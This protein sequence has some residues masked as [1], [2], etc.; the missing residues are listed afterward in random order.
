MQNS[1]YITLEISFD[2]NQRMHK[3]VKLI[4]RNSKTQRQYY[5]PMHINEKMK[6]SKTVIF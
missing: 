1:K 4:I 2:E 3:I 5:N 6:L